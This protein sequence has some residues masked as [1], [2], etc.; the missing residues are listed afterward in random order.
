MALLQTGGVESIARQTLIYMQTEGANMTGRCQRP[1]VNETT[2]REYVDKY[3]V[4]EEDLQHAYDLVLDMDDKHRSGGM[5]AQT[6][7]ATYDRKVA[8]PFFDQHEVAKSLCTDGVTAQRQVLSREEVERKQKEQE[9]AELEATRAQG[10]QGGGGGPGM[11]QAVT[12]AMEG[13]ATGGAQ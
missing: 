8:S 2:T 4:T 9:A 10:A 5:D 11:A 12:G 1:A 7:L 6:N 3:E 13:G